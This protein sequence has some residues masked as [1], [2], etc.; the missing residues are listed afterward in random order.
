[1]VTGDIMDYTTIRGV[2][3][4]NF[5]EHISNY[6]D[7]N[8]LTMVWEDFERKAFAFLLDQADSNDLFWAVISDTE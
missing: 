2:L 6:V 3:K 4:K 1:M 8:D 7:I 5:D